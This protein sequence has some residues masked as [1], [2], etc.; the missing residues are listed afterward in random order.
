MREVTGST[1]REHG[2]ALGVTSALQLVTENPAGSYPVIELDSS[3]ALWLA[4]S[5][6]GSPPL[7]GAQPPRLSHV[8]DHA[9]GA[10]IS[11]GNRTENVVPSPNTLAT[12]ISPPSCCVNRRVMLSPSPV[13]PY[14]RV[15]D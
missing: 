10:R 1:H 11:N 5:K 9:P 4:R 7:F 6:L 14:D 13:P 3:P 15:R 8:R 2:K 12:W